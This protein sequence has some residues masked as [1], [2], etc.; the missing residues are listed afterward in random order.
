MSKFKNSGKKRKF[1]RLP[2]I[3][4]LTILL[5]IGYARYIEPYN[6]TEQEIS[7]TTDNLPR[8]IKIAIFADTHFSKYYTPENF[9]DVVSRINASAPD[10]VF[11]LGDLV[12][13][14]STYDGDITEIEKQLASINA[15]MG[16]F[17]VYGNHDYGGKMQFTYPDIIEAGGFRLLVNEIAE[18]DDM[19]ISI[20]GIDDMVIGYGNPASAAGLA[21]NS[22][23]IA[24]CHE[25]DIAD[26]ITDYNVDV[27]F[28][29]H[30]H[31][32][33]INLKIFDSYILPKYGKKY[34]KGN[35]DLDNIRKTSLYVT[36]G[37]G[38]TKLPFRFASPPEINLITIG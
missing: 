3:I 30:T 4:I 2:L 37:I 20:L 11:F 24:L 7:Y 29:G 38:M 27:M 33:Q 8:Q 25:P 1:L 34:I 17:A 9:S 10:L 28:A 18:F 12:D 31:G 15:R 14:F 22:Y 16:K 13:D 21:E 26:Q 35:F 23:N 6:L 5:L 19:N 32:R 36:S